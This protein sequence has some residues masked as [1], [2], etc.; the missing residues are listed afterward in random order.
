[1]WY[2]PLVF[3]SIS[4]DPQQKDFQTSI[5]SNSLHPLMEIHTLEIQIHHLQLSLN[6]FLPRSDYL[7]LLFTFLLKKFVLR[8]FLRVDFTLNYQVLNQSGS[9][10][11]NQEFRLPNLSSKHFSLLLMCEL[12]LR[13]FPSL[14][15]YL[16]SSHSTLIQNSE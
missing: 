15:P 13:D 7:K 8:I 16:W 14:H 6:H 3:L 10:N 5:I 11:L 2:L 12:N 4:I 1:M 9:Q